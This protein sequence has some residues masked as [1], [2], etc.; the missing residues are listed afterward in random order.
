MIAI[1]CA[2]HRYYA[3]RSPPNQG[4][5]VFILYDT[6]GEHCVARNEAVLPLHE[7]I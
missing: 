4:V 7:M 2:V 6:V 5:T 1:Y 3:M